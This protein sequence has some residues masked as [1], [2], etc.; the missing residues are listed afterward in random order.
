M[1]YMNPLG[2]HNITQQNKAQQNHV[3]ILL[4]ILCTLFINIIT[5]VIVISLTLSLLLLSLSY[6]EIG[7]YIS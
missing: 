3:L 6:N 1:Y 5:A 4:D 7:I 2:T